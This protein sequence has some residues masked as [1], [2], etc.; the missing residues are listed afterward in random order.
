[1]QSRHR[2]VDVTCGA[3]EG[4]LQVISTKLFDDRG[5]KAETTSQQLRGG[6]EGGG[7]LA[8]VSHPDYLKCGKDNLFNLSYFPPYLQRLDDGIAALYG[9]VHYEGLTRIFTNKAFARTF[10]S[11][12]EGAA[13][14][15]VYGI[16]PS[17]LAGR[18]VELWSWV[19][20][21]TSSQWW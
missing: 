15:K 14:I 11:E 6:A 1:M 10:F 4:L 3:A 2:R 17:I 8:D 5:E 21:L 7:E 19:G 18:C 16:L 9:F 20:L 13:R 12:E